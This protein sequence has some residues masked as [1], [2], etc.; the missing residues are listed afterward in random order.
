MRAARAEPNGVAAAAAEGKKDTG[1][2]DKKGKG[3]EGDGVPVA[4]AAAPV[5]NTTEAA[6]RLTGEGLFAH[7]RHN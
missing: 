7:V 4:A 6:P 2:K 5:D 1:K 3:E